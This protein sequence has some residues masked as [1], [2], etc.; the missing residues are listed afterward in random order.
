MRSL[1]PDD[2]TK[3]QWNFADNETTAFLETS[4][5]DQA[6]GLIDRASADR[7]RFRKAAPGHRQ[8]ETKRPRLRARPKLRRRDETGSL[9]GREIFPAPVAPIERQVGEWCARHVV[10]PC[11]SAA[12]KKTRQDCTLC[13]LAPGT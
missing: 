9:G 12:R 2:E 8:E 3:R 5:G 6:F 13:S 1:Q 11:A 7:Q 10:A 4:N